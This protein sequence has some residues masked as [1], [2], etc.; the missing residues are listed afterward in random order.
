MQYLRYCFVK[1]IRCGISQTLHR[2]SCLVDDGHG[3]IVRMLKG[4]NPESDFGRE[5]RRNECQ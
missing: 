5:Y 2:Q 3:S 1:H 4:M